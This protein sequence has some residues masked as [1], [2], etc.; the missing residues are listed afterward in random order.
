MNLFESLLMEIAVDFQM[1]HLNAPLLFC[2]IPAYGDDWIGIVNQ[3]ADVYGFQFS[4]VQWE[5]GA[6]WEIRV[7]ILR[8]ARIR[9]YLCHI[10]LIKYLSGEIAAELY[11]VF[12]TV[13]LR[14]KPAKINWRW[15]LHLLTFRDWNHSFCEIYAVRY[16][17]H[18][19]RLQLTTH[20]ME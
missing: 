4:L 17:S 9:R 18:K 19:F 15:L 3:K 20:K 16:E 2:S 12:L 11:I 8:I 14:L 10:T 1:E 13:G 7:C 5:N 6:G